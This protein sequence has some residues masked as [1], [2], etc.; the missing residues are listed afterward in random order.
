MTLE[1]GALYM[2]IYVLAWFHQ[3]YYLIYFWDIKCDK[4]SFQLYLEVL[5]EDRSKWLTVTREWRQKYTELKQ[6]VGLNY[7][8]LTEGY[9]NVTISF[10][11]S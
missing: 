1:P 8:M 7:F 10:D 2:I 3:Q 4:F 5:P 9:D 11:P 6:R